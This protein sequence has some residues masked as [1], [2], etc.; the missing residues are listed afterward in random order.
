MTCHSYPHINYLGKNKA[1][2]N[3]KNNIYLKRADFPSRMVLSHPRT[4]SVAP[5]F[6]SDNK[7][8]ILIF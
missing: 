3:K 6:Q 2:Q 8:N 5:L 4:P 7:V 1:K